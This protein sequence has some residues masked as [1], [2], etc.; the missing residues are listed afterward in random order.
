MG[1]GLSRPDAGDRACGDKF[2]GEQMRG[3]AHRLSSQALLAEGGGPN[4]R[5]LGDE[6]RESAPL[7]VLASALRVRVLV[8]LTLSVAMAVVVAVVVM[9]VA[10]SISAGEPMALES[11]ASS[12]LGAISSTTWTSLSSTFREG[13]GGGETTSML[14][15]ETGIIGESAS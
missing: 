8:A 10:A 14:S 1:T 15:G 4:A 13:A 9:V 6:D 3:E 2:T 7:S 12:V 11:A 5:D